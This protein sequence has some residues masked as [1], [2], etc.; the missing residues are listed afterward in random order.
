MA[1]MKKSQK[2][3]E[4]GSEKRIPE[5]AGEDDYK[6]E[7]EP[8]D[9][10]ESDTKPPLKKRTKKEKKIK[11][12][13]RFEDQ[14]KAMSDIGFGGLSELKLT[15]VQ[16]RILPWLCHHFIEQSCMFKVDLM[17]ELSVS[18]YDVTFLAPV[19]NRVID[20][21]IIKYCDNVKE[22]PN[23][24]WCSYVLE[25]LWNAIQRMKY[26]K[27]KE[28]RSGI[29]GCI[30]VLQIAYFHHVA[31]RGHP[32]PTE[33]P[34][35]KHWTDEKIK[36]RISKEV[37]ASFGQ[38]ELQK[39]SYPVCAK[40]GRFN[41][42]QH[43][44]ARRYVTY[45]IPSTLFSDIEIHEKEVEEDLMLLLRDTSL[46][47]MLHANRINAITQR[48]R[49]VADIN[50]I[51]VEKV[52]VVTQTQRLLGDPRVQRAFDEVV[53]L[54]DY[55]KDNT[56]VFYDTY[57]EQAAKHKEDLNQDQMNAEYID[58]DTE[59]N[60]ADDG[61]DIHEEPNEDLNNVVSSVTKNCGEKDV[62][63]NFVS[64][65]MKSNKSRMNE[66]PELY[67]V[68]AD[69]CFVK[70][71]AF[72]H[73]ELVRYE[74]AFMIT[75]DDTVSL[76]PTA[77]PPKM[78]KS[79]IVQ[80]WS[81]LMNDLRLKEDPSCCF[82][83]IDHNPTPKTDKKE[84]PSPSTYTAEL[85]EAWYDWM[86]LCEA[87]K[88]IMTA[89]LIFVPIFLGNHYNLVVVNFL[90]ETI[91]YLDN[92]E[93]DD[94]H[95]PFYKILASLVVEEMSNF[96]KRINHEKADEILDY[97]FDEVKFKWKT[98]K[99]TLDCGV[100]IM[101]HMLC[102]T[103]DPFDS[104][105]D[106]AN[107]RKVYC[108]KIC[109]TL[110]LAE[111]NTKR[112]SLMEKVS[113]FK[114]VRKLEKEKEVKDMVYVS[115]FLKTRKEVMES[116]SLKCNQVIDYL[117]INDDENFPNKRSTLSSFV[118]DF[119]LIFSSLAFCSN[120]VFSWGPLSLI[121]VVG[122]AFPTLMACV[123]LSNLG[124]AVTEVAQDALIAEYGQKH[125][126]VGL[127][128][129]TFMAIAVAG[130][131]G[132][133]LGGILLSKS[134][135]RTLLSIFTLLLSVQLLISISTKEES[136]GL[137][138]PLSTIVEQSSS[139]SNIKRQFSDLLVALSD[140]K[141]S[142]PLFWVVASIAMVPMLTGSIFCYQTQSLNLDPSVIGVSKVIG[143]MLLLS[144]TVLYDRYWKN[145][146]IRKL[147]GIVQF[148][149]AFSLLLDLV[150]VTQS[151]LK[152]GIPNNVFA[153]CFSGLA[154]T[155][156]TFKTVPF[157]V[158]IG[159]LC[160]SGCEASVTAFLASALTLSTIVSGFFGIG[161]AS[162][163]GITSDN[164]TSLSV[165]IMLQS[166]AALVPLVWINNLPIS[167]LSVEKEK[168]KGR[169]KRSRK[170]RRVGRVTLNSIF[171]YRR[172]RESET[173]R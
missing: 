61:D 70:Y 84:K 115:N 156:A 145:I 25:N 113:R 18:N 59:V 1:N 60:I 161:L 42:Y 122:E 142:R 23:L 64:K 8:S 108:A 14:R 3:N 16:T 120:V 153:L 164:Y 134:H 68:E 118:G 130:I 139:L 62:E 131:L 10:E 46:F 72:K 50:T 71:S 104:D 169:S 2:K 20:N 136:L 29:S 28:A 73:E 133:S 116:M 150:L 87:K 106:L 99:Y 160:P 117:A 69:Y 49:D 34:L 171:S 67:Q 38:G 157:F 94:K 132:N 27:N 101:M 43:F 75:R 83:G 54:Y 125:K 37:K 88:K 127:Q 63:I 6:P 168:K 114:V 58:P 24:D 33:L 7:D 74:A 158:L 85:N 163:L 9:D 149:Y 110:S 45:D 41:E 81:F 52:E 138:K 97:E 86:C 170:N 91:Q 4:K 143:Q 154:E 30:L 159:S 121:P 112:K 152:F 128:S 151:N 80:C 155:I 26:N 65:W 140:D 12:Y 56:N 96:L 5:P 102:F 40:E 124:A 141:I 11:R 32:E 51:L 36:T 48:L 95:K 13:K 55:L 103:G 146:P 66:I 92:R 111:I 77:P 162:V 144:L 44:A 76:A 39:E 173:Q 57:Q 109:A 167:Q 105:L 119:W 100:F 93:Y 129:Y 147:I 79:S 35:I 78:I 137:S 98:P 172:K 53:R 89:Q 135:P 31:F 82:F 90:K 123:L 107:R 165:G 22:I 166:L 19:A 47:S 126:I 17:K 21:K 15:Y 148:L